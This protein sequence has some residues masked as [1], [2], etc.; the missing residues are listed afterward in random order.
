MRREN[1]F[2]WKLWAFWGRL[3]RLQQSLKTENFAVW[4]SVIKRVACAIETNAEKT[5]VRKMFV[6]HEGKKEIEVQVSDPTIYTVDYSWFFDEIAKKIED[7]VRVPEFI[8]GMTADFSTT[9]PVQKI[10]S[11]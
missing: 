6:N 9:T 8:D 4:F 2:H 10:V 7:N 5:S 3:H 1:L 11:Q